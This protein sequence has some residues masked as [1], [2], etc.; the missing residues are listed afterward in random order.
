MHDIPANDSGAM[1]SLVSITRSLRAS[2]YAADLWATDDGRLRCGRCGA[3]HDPAVLEIAQVHRF[4]GDSDPG[5]EAILFAIDAPPG[6]H[7]GIY[8]AAY[9]PEMPP[10]DV[11]IVRELRVRH[12]A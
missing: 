2:G 9:G 5:E 11:A 1:D 7:R 10:S 3:V 6:C 12:V 4:E 8:S